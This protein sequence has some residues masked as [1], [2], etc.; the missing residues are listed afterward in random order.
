MQ[1]RVFVLG[2]LVIA[3]AVFGAAVVLS[4]VNRRELRRRLMGVHLTQDFEGQ[5]DSATTV[6]TTG[7]YSVAPGLIDIDGD[8]VFHFGKSTCE[9]S[10]FSGHETTLRIAFPAPLFVR[11]VSFREKELDSNWGSDG[12]VLLDGVPWK[13]G[14]QGPGSIVFNHF[15]RPLYNDIMPDE[16]FRYRELQVCREVTV[17]ELKVTDITNRSAIVIDDLIIE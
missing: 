17:V 14:V 5:L 10:C 9:A 7:T 2:L 4:Y 3:G 11:T 1:K 15:G 13:K 12:V 16:E 6:A 8:T